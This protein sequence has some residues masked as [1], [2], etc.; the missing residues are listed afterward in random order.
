MNKLK[1]ILLLAYAI[2]PT[3][4]S[5]YAVG[6]NFLTYLAKN[7]KVFVLTGLSGEH[8]GDTEEV[9]KY[10]QNNPNPNIKLI[11]VKPTKLAKFINWPN[12]VGILGPIFYLAFPFWQKE[13]YKI[14]KEIVANEKIDIVH[15]LNPI[16]FREPG[17][18]WKLDKPFV[19]GPIGGAQFI[20]YKLL[21]NHP[22]TSKVFFFIKNII[23][24]IQLN[25]NRRIRKAAN[26]SSML[27][28]STTTNRT[29]FEK[30]Y[31]K[32]GPIIS[33][34]AS[35]IID[36]ALDKRVVDT[37]ALDIVWIGQ[38]SYRKNLF[39]L[40]NALSLVKNKSK[41]RLNIIGD[42]TG[43]DKLKDIA[44]KLAI[45]KN[46]IWHGSKVR[47]EAVSIIQG[48]DLHAMT[49]L[50]EA[51]TTV[52]YEAVSSGIPTISLD[53][54]GMHSTLAN[55]NGILVEV[56]TYDETIKRYANRI[57]ELIENPELLTTLKQKT[58]S[59]IDEFSWE[60][61]IQK[62]EEIYDN[63]ISNY[64]KQEK[65]VTKFH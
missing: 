16:G 40:F 57:D 30:Y 58:I 28:F 61:K 54:D 41:W 52:L 24:F 22:L 43:V 31:G 34:Q 5:E 11:S 18:L 51:N 46:I 50:S 37:D 20:N 56:S 26:I 1:T 64:N 25:C 32:T 48:A 12:K 13:A 6:W 19:W 49:S 7:N 44:E 27:I 39:L 9:E 55:G 14:A 47:T 53:Q 29:N 8:M 4:G 23:N 42:G 36:L 45:S 63:A 33:E 17:Y 35:F 21:K 65:H 38:I 2:S 60:K 15:H 62:V 10:F 59:L 3:K